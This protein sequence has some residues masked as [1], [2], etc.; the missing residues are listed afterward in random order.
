MSRLPAVV[1]HADS[2]GAVREPLLAARAGN[3]SVRG[4]PRAGR[5]H[6]GVGPQHR[7]SGGI[8]NGVAAGVPPVSRIEQVIRAALID[9]GRSLDERG[10]PGR[11][12][13]E[14]AGRFAGQRHPVVTEGLDPQ[15]GR[16]IDGVGIRLPEQIGAAVHVD[17]GTGIDRSAQWQ[18]ID[19]RPGAVVHI[20][21]SG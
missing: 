21:T 7:R 4:K 17:E 13:P 5:G 19:E 14:Q 20:G 8:A 1:R 15:A 12:V 18:L 11:V 6:F 9:H 10:L 16:L 3:G 2:A